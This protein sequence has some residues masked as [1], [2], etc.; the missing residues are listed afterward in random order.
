ME[1]LRVFLALLSQLQLANGIELKA[2]TAFRKIS[3]YSSP[4][5]ALFKI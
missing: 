1:L 5:T 4:N 3:G 2:I